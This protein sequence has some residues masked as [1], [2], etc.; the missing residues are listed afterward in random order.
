M[1]VQMLVIALDDPYLE[2]QLDRIADALNDDE[3]YRPTQFAAMLASLAEPDMT[4]TDEADE[5]QN[6]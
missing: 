5:P 4:G 6:Q 2:D 3:R 1:A